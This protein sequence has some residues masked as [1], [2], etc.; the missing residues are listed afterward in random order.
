MTTTAPPKRDADLALLDNILW[1][2]L[3]GAQAP[4]GAGGPNAKRYARGYSPIAAFADVG[5]PDF[6]ELA[7]HVEPGE[8]LY[9][10]GWHGPVPDGWTLESDST[11]FQMVW[12]GPAP[13]GRA[14]DVVPLDAR[15]AAEMVALAELTHPGPFGPRTV[16]MGRYLGVIEDGRLVAMAGE[17]MHAGRLREVSGVA[18]HPDRQGRGLARSLMVRLLQEEIARGEIPFLHVRRTNE[19]ARALYH[20][21]GF[22]EHRELPVRRI[23]RNG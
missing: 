22:R 17:R 14:I 23:A 5:Q 3:T 2:C 21:M 16:E 12:G 4:I 10:G 20:R 8:T 13:S 15:H 9:V 18:T 6:V 11:M 1:H 7:R 19:H